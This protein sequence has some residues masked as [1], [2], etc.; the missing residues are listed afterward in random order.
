MDRH[1]SSD[2]KDL[3]TG[4]AAGW[5]RTQPQVVHPL[6]AAKVHRVQVGHPMLWS[7][8]EHEH[9]PARVARIATVDPAVDGE[10]GRD[11]R[12]VFARDQAEREVDDRLRQ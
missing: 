8:V 11:A 12:Q 2:P 3:W 5:A 10:C 9:M 6:C 7:R 1:Y 4:G